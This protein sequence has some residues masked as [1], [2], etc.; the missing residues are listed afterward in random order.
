MV[1]RTKPWLTIMLCALAPLMPCA[2]ASG[3]EPASAYNQPAA[4]D[5]ASLAERMDKLEAKQRDLE[6]EVKD[7][8]QEKQAVQAQL[9]HQKQENAAMK[10]RTDVPAVFTAGEYSEN[11]RRRFEPT[12]E[13]GTRV[14]YQDFPYHQAHGGFFYSFFINHALFL[15][16]EGVPFG[17]LSAEI[18]VGY[19]SSGTDQ[20]NDFSTTLLQKYILNYRQT[21]LSG[22]IGMR[23]T[24]NHWAVQGLRPYVVAG[25]GIWGDVIETPP[26]YIGQQLPS[27]AIAARKVPVV[28]GANLYGG[29]QGG[30]GFEYNLGATGVP[31]LRRVNVG[32]DYRYSAWMSGERFGTYTFSLSANE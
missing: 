22:W 11:P 7:L 16:E 27:A 1:R 13:W 17:D 19:G 6:A 15:E 3:A 20:L 23:Y 5:S 21:M 24:L 10:A 26:L 29:G 31:L 4:V 8:R 32:L 14:G 28:S 12:T 30:A 9:E 18:N 2:M 25:P